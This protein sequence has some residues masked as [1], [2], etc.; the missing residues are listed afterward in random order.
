[1][2]LELRS[3][4]W[5][6]DAADH[7]D[8]KAGTREPPQDTSVPTNRFRETLA[9]VESAAPLMT[10]IPIDEY[11]KRDAKP[12]ELIPHPR[13]VT[14]IVTQ[15]I[16]DE[17][18]VRVHRRVGEDRLLTDGE[19]QEWA[20]RIQALPVAPRRIWM[21]WNTNFEMQAFENAQRLEALLPPALVLDWH[22]HYMEMQKANKVSTILSCSFFFLFC[23]GSILSFFGA[24]PSP[25][26][27]A[28][29][30]AAAADKKRASPPRAAASA[31]DPGPQKKAKPDAI[32]NFFKKK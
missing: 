32:N 9:W 26:K 7:A 18:Y 21:M 19:L 22:Q 29:D 15:L 3:D 16:G 24:A 31:S 28:A 14:P 6:F 23:Q 1:M 20:R 4:S 5:F 25:K 10:L 13:R 8:F 12:S 27:A 17:M 30:K 11:A 2:A